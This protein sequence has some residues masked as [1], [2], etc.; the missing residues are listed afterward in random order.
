MC[1]FSHCI[2]TTFYVKCTSRRQDLMVKLLPR[3]L[4]GNNERK[5]TPFSYPVEKNLRKIDHY[6]H[7]T[8]LPRKF[9]KRHQTYFIKLVQGDGLPQN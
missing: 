1:T 7:S 6:Q 2:N 9:D 8:L 5:Q 4:L 3:Y